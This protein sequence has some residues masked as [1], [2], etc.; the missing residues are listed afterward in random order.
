MKKVYWLLLVA[1]AAILR[2]GMECIPSPDLVDPLGNIWVALGWI[3][4]NPLT[5]PT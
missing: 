2:L 3:P 5:S 1:S 4:E